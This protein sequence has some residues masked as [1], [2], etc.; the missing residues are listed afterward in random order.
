MCDS[1]Q[2]KI[3]ERDSLGIGG[4]RGIETSTEQNDHSTIP[5]VIFFLPIE[6]SVYVSNVKF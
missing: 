6:N 1:K 2:N 4:T 3:K 5:Y